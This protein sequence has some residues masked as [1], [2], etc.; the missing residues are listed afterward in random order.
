VS[1]FEA[2]QGRGIKAVREGHT[3]YVGGPRL[4]ELLQLAPPSAIA[5]FEQQQ[6]VQGRSVVYLVQDG[7][8]IAAFALADVIR[9]ESKEAVA[10]LHEMG[11]AVAMLTGDSRAVAESVAR[12]LGIDQVF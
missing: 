1:R 9:P 3:V 12:E 6:S 5:D 8:V 4:L 7:Q 11:V 10:R 2:I